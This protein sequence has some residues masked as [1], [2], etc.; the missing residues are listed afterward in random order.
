MKKLNITF[1]SFP[2]FSSN[3]KPLYE[4]MVKK[5]KDT[6]NFVW[7]VRT[8]EMY[9]TLNKKNITAYKLGTDEYFK[10][11]KNSDIFFTTHADIIN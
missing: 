7:V 11:I 9:E 10:Y 4:Y 6:M 3:A 2:D 1:C 5:Y 8:D